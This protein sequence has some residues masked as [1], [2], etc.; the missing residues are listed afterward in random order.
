MLQNAIPLFTH[1]TLSEIALTFFLVAGR[2]RARFIEPPEPPVVTMPLPKMFNF[3]LKMHQN[4]RS[5]WRLGSAQTLESFPQLKEPG[6]REVKEMAIGRGKGK[7]RGG[8]GEESLG[9]KG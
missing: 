8:E 6:V 7:G 9:G 1:R 5:I 3:T 2:S 4:S